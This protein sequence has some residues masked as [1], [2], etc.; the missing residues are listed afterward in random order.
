MSQICS[1]FFRKVCNFKNSA[2]YSHHLFSIK[3]QANAHYNPACKRRMDIVLKNTSQNS[4]MLVA[5]KL[6]YIGKKSKQRTHSIFFLDLFQFY[7]EQTDI[8]RKLSCIL[9]V[10]IVMVSMFQH[11]VHIKMSVSVHGAAWRQTAARKSEIIQ[12]GGHPVPSCL[13][14]LC[15]CRRLTPGTRTRHSASITLVMSAK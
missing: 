15:L 10:V 13:P 4:C 2:L 8:C 6:N 12:F 7:L 1:I 11:Q 5:W 9:R 14:F 3:S